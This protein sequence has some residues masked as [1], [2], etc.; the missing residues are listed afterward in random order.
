MTV[1]ELI[2]YLQS[3]PPDQ[4]VVCVSPNERNLGYSP[5]FFIDGISFHENGEIREQSRPYQISCNNVR[6]IQI[7]KRWMVDI[8]T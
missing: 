6:V 4:E 8:I 1:Q 7:S 2:D 5:A 3:Y